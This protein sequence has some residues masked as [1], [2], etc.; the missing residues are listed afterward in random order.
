MKE[1]LEF[2]KGNHERIGWQAEVLIGLG[3]V[4]G[5]FSKDV[6]L[7]VHLEGAGAFCNLLAWAMFSAGLVVALLKAFASYFQ[8]RPARGVVDGL[9][10]GLLAGIVGGALGW[11]LHQGPAYS[12]PFVER[13]ALCTLFALPVGA[14]LGLCFDLLHPDRAIKWRL[15]IGGLLIALIFLFL[16]VSYGMAQFLPAVD[17]A[18]ISLGDVELLFEVFTVLMAAQAAFS[19]AWSLTRFARQVIWL[20]APL[21]LVRLATY[22]IPLDD[23]CQDPVSHR[24]AQ[25]QFWVPADGAPCPNGYA[26]FPLVILGFMVSAFVAYS[27]YFKTRRYPDGKSGQITDPAKSMNA[28][29]SPTVFIEDGD[30]GG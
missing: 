7:P 2:L 21:L 20:A 19:F 3:V 28:L 14:V 9:A 4:I 18:G 13:V 29:A 1:L 16:L 10:A 26:I 17:G 6:P 5:L 22:S 23:R 24:L 25:L 15:Y 27:L 11:G 12:T 8:N 30:H